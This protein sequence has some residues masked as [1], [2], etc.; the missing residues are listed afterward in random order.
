MESI[1]VTN[2]YLKIKGSTTATIRETD[3]LV[4]PIIVE[5][6]FLA[7]EKSIKLS[8]TATGGLKIQP[9]ENGRKLKKFR[10][11]FPKALQKKLGWKPG[12]TIEFKSK[13]N[14][15]VINKVDRANHPSFK[16]PSLDKKGIPIPPAWMVQAFTGIPDIRNFLKSGP[17]SVKKI[18]QTANK[19]GI[20][21]KDLRNVLD[22]GCGCGRILSRWNEYPHVNMTG[23]DLHKVAIKWCKRHY[24]NYSFYNGTELPPSPIKDASFDLVYAISVLTHLDEKHQNSWLAE[25]KRITRPGGLVI[26]T[27]RGDDFV[28]N[29]IGS[30]ERR[31]SIAEEFKS[32]GGI[33][34]NERPGWEGV[35]KSFYGGTYHTREY[36]EREWGKHFEIL[37]LIDSGQFINRQNAAIMR[38]I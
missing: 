37:E 25:W 6:T 7:T 21:T 1:L 38:R 31:K 28:E 29:V 12:D 23:C 17:K 14:R 10:I 30:P 32:G 2:Q 27:F 16:N 36:V 15:I 8:P 13:K 3:I 9:K 34:F 11:D 5:S 35:F 22:F 4:P 19:W 20:D 26:A 24:S 33:S 18:I